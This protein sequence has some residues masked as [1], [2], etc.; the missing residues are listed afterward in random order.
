[1]C[2]VMV[3]HVSVSDVDSDDW[4]FTARTRVDF[5]MQ[6]V[7]F[8]GVLADAAMVDAALDMDLSSVHGAS[9]EHLCSPSA[10]IFGSVGFIAY[11]YWHERGGF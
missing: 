10:G 2:V 11:G 9:D 5:H 3:S 7:V 4:S 6:R 8:A 1:M